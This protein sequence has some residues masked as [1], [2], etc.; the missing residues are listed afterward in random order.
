M[1]RYWPAL[2][3]LLARTRRT[4]MGFM[5]GGAGSRA[6]GWRARGPLGQTNRTVGGTGP[7]CELRRTIPKKNEFICVFMRMSFHVNAFQP[8]PGPMWCV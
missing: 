1:G 4:A 5:I 6:R 7:L 2:T 3:L 8:T